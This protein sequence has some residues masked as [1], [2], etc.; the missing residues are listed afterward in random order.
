MKGVM[1]DSKHS[2]QAL[3]A[4]IV[5]QQW[6]QIVA[7]VTQRHVR[8]VVE[9]E[10]T[11]VMAIVPLADLQ[12]LAQLDEERAQFLAALARTQAL[13]ADVPDGDLASEIDRA[14][15]AARTTTNGPYH[16]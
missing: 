1:V 5:T 10:G 15:V 7:Q 3:D 2:S 13:F 16:P 11:P 12:R 4:G 8:I 6:E 9:A 14:L